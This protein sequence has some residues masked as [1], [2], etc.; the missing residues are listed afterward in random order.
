LALCSLGG[1]VNTTA[2]DLFIDEMA[3]LA[4]AEP[5]EFRLRHLYDL[6]ANEGIQRAA[7]TYGWDARPAAPDP[8]AAPAEGEMLTGRGIAFACD[9]T[10]FTDVAVVVEVEAD[11]GP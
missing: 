2:N 9:E 10:E 3:A 6:R 1:L 5:V 8:N 7:E 4:G 11:P